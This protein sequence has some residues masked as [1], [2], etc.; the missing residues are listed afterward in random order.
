MSITRR[1]YMRNRT[2]RKIKCFFGFHAPD[3]IYTQGE[4]LVQRCLYCDKVV[5]R[6][7]NKD[8]KIRRIQ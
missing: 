5:V 1:Y 7:E 8:Q 4:Y 6:L 2:V 3:T